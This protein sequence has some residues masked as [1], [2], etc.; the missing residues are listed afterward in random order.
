MTAGTGIDRRTGGI[1][2]GWAHVQQSL[3]VLFTTARES[4]VMRRAVGSSVPRMVDQP[5]NQV[6]LIDF[7]AAVAKAI[8]DYEPRFKVSKMSVQSASSGQLTIAIQGVYY[9]RGH[10]GDFSVSEPQVVSVP[11]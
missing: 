6:T 1:L 7:Y 2:S 10:L 5:M 11:L 8:R 4:R 9:P 3:E